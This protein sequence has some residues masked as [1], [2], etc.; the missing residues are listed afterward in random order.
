MRVLGVLHP[1]GGS[2]GLLAERAAAAGHELVEW[3]PGRG[4]PIPAPLDEFGALVVFGGGMN[5]RDA[6]RLPWLHG[7]LELLRDAVQAEL[8]VLG[9]CLG[10]QLLAAA[11]GAEVHRASEPE[12]GWFDVT[13]TAPDPVLDALP[14]RFLAYEWHSY[15]FDLPA[16]ATEL[17]RSAVCTQAY[18]LG[19][20][21][22]G[23][24]FHPEVTPAIVAF[25]AHDFE[26]DP[27]AVAMDFDPEHHIAVAS[28]RLPAWMAIGRALFDAFLATAATAGPA[29]APRPEARSAQAPPLPRG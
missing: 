27:D 19:E 24:Q 17:A 9:V 10:A 5:V 3:N 14:E 28:E 20:A 7:E 11:A 22:W 18:R 26:S 15:T 25:W 4:E 16:G 6:E 2:S 12:I 1:G 23:V 13:R 8:P 29:P 21:A